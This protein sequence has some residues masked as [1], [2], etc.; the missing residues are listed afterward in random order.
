MKKKFLAIL[1]VF[2]LFLSAC[3]NKASDN[4]KDSNKYK[5]KKNITIF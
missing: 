3:G 1:L 4:S 2:V 5:L